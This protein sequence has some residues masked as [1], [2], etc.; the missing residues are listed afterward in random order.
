MSIVP[1]R[2]MRTTRNGVS[3]RVTSPC[4]PT[5]AGAAARASA[6]QV[7]AVPLPEPAHGGFGRARVHRLRALAAHVDDR[8]LVARG[9]RAALH[10]ATDAAV[11]H[12]DVA[13]GPDQVGLAQP[14]LP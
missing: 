4:V 2:M 7:A 11:L 13:G 14:P 9:G 10:E 5:S 8:E 3:A 12:R 6:P 1:S